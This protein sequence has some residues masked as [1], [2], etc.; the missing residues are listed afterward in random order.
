MHKWLEALTPENREI[1]DNFLKK[2]GDKADAMLSPWT[3]EKEALMAEL[4]KWKKD[5][6]IAIDRYKKISKGIK[7]YF[8][9][10]VL[11][12]AAGFF[13]GCVLHS[14]S[15]NPLKIIEGY[16]GPRWMR[17]WTVALTFGAIYNL[18]N[19]LLF[20]RQLKKLNQNYRRWR[21]K[22]GPRK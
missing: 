13:I 2:L 8:P 5:E 15:Y 17:C 19:S 9:S 20:P 22:M 4:F 1:A 12:M 11:V 7:Y 16:I 3:P 6:A 21:A 10:L 14:T 18:V